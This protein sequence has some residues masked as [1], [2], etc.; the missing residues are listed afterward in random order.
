M[1]NAAVAREIKSTLDV[2]SKKIRCDSTIKKK[3]QTAKI[4]SKETALEKE[5]IRKFQQLFQGPLGKGLRVFVPE[6]QK[7]I[8]QII[9]LN[10]FST[11]VYPAVHLEFYI[12][13]TINLAQINKETLGSNG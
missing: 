4:R 11:S 5:A 9:R 13:P 10:I 2:F 6:P 7:V 8:K 1:F 3:E 12:V